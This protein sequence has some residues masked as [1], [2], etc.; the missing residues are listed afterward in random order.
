MRM[1]MT[2][3]KVDATRIHL[4]ILIVVKPPGISAEDPIFVC[5]TK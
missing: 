3:T 4:K 5:R 1:G 2:Y